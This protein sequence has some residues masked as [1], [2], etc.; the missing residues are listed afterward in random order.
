MRFKGRQKEHQE[1][2]LEI[3]NGLI[4]QLKGVAETQGEP[5]FEGYY[6]SVMLIPVGE[7]K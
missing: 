2:G 1:V 7:G 6:M 5:K 4:E 3:L